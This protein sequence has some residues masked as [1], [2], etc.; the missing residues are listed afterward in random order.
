M[1]EMVMVS[2]KIGNMLVPKRSIFF[3]EVY[4][5]NTTKTKLREV[6]GVERLPKIGKKYML[7]GIDV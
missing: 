5:N 6:W 2:K 4:I 3:L 1:Y 7:R